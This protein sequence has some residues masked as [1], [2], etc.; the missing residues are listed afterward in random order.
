MVLS[1]FILF[2]FTVHPGPKHFFFP[3]LRKFSGTVLSNMFSAPFSLS[4]PFGTSIMQ[5][6]VYL[7]CL[8]GFLNYLHFFFFFLSACVISTSLSS[9]LLTY[10][11]ISSNLLLIPSSIFLN[12]CYY[13]LQFCL[14]LL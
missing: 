6:L 10:S 14:I 12:F 3:S 5:I 13:T 2:E 1:G 8:R 9:S 11:C 4:S 7:M